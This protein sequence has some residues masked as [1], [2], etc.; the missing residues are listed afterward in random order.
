MKKL[1]TKEMSNLKGGIFVGYQLAF[2]HKRLA[3]AHKRFSDVAPVIADSTIK[4]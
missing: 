4:K 2:T 1:N 3:F